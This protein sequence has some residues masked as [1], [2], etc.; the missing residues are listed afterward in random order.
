ML[1]LSM[2]VSN[3]LS[4][5]RADHKGAMLASCCSLGAADS[6]PEQR[7]LH[8]PG[9]KQTDMHITCMITM[10]CSR[11]SSSSMRAPCNSCQTKSKLTWSLFNSRERAGLVWQKLQISR[12]N[13]ALVVI[14]KAAQ[15][16]QPWQHGKYGKHQPTG[17]KKDPTLNPPYR[18]KVLDGLQSPHGALDSDEG[19]RENSRFGMLLSDFNGHSVF[20]RHGSSV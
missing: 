8:V 5:D 4:V 6:L 10:P 11:S 1:N 16:L 15:I 9:I 3:Q 17:D 12:I 20:G 13:L 7:C 18:W 2:P 14:G 19:L